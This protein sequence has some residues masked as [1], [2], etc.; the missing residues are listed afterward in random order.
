MEHGFQDFRVSGLWA[1]GTA[2]QGSSRRR[3]RTR[4]TRL[5]AEL[6]V[7]VAAVVHQREVGRQVPQ[8]D[9]GPGGIS[10]VLLQ[11]VTPPGPKDSKFAGVGGA[12][13][14]ATCRVLAR[15]QQVL[16]VLTERD[17]CHLLPHARG[18]LF[19]FVVCAIPE[20]SRAISCEVHAVRH[21]PR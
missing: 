16:A 9:C 21:N 19:C 14:C 13:R 7:A 3:H 17:R 5:G 11:T 4:G 18:F 2:Q 6:L 10:A 8:H 1:L 15:A 12:E 20:V